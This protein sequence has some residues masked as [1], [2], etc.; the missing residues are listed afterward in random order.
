MRCSIPGR[1]MSQFSGL[2]LVRT[3]VEGGSILIDKVI[4]LRNGQEVMSRSFRTALTRES[5]VLE[6]SINMEDY[7]KEMD[8]SE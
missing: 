3:S 2:R 6:V 5:P 8:S 4:L 7:A 1:K